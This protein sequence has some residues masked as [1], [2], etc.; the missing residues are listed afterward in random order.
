MIEREPLQY[1]ISERLEYIAARLAYLHVPKYIIREVLDADADFIK[2]ILQKGDKV[3]IQDLG[4]FSLQYVPPRAGFFM[5][6]NALHPDGFQMPDLDEYNRVKFRPY[7]RI[8]DDFRKRTYGNAF[9][10]PLEETED[11]DSIDEVAD[12]EEIE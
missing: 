11:E 12:G 9:H 7:K 6:P 8:R 4:V 10:R 5:P 2:L 1:G 3:L